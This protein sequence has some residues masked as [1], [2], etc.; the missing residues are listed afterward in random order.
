MA[1]QAAIRDRI[2]ELRRVRPGDLL[3][4]PKNWRRHPQAQA[5][6][7]RAV[8]DEVGFADVLLARETADGLMLID[9]HLRA[10]IAADAEVP[11]LVLDLD[12][13]EADKLLLTLDPLAAMAE[14]GAEALERLVADVQTD[15]DTLRA[16]IDELAQNAGI[17]PP[18]FRPIGEDEQSRLDE[19]SKVTCPECG[20]E[21]T[22]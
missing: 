10:E 2:V 13:E 14:A 16:M 8:L 15:S 4:N 11:V 17:S 22:P 6:A 7:L 12:S 20:H 9:G 5:E 1:Q 3:P 21:F 18:D 19:R